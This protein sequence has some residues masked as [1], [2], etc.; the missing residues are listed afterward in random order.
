MHSLPYSFPLWFVTRCWI[1]FPLVYSRILL[2][3]HSVYNSL[4]LFIPNSPSIPSSSP[5]L[6]TKV[7]SKSVSLFLLLD[8]FIYVIESAYKWYR[9]IY[10][11]YLTYSTWYDNTRSIHVAANGIISLF[12]WLSSIPLCIYTTS[13]LFIHLLG[14]I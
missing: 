12:W 9:G 4:H 5:H 1:E 2:F 13:S 8:G 7:C 10:L 6:A 11:S 14:D 3:I